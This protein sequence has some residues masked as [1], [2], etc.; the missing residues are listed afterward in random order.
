MMIHYGSP[1]IVN[2]RDSIF[3]NVTY[4]YRSITNGPRNSSVADLPVLSHLAVSTRHNLPVTLANIIAASLSGILKQCEKLQMLVLVLDF[5]SEFLWNL[6]LI[7]AWDLR[8]NDCF[9]D[10]RFVL[11]PDFRSPRWEWD[12]IV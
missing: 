3:E 1:H 10:E 5:G 9:L 2:Y 7:T 6:E 12:D 8:L 4:F 11:L